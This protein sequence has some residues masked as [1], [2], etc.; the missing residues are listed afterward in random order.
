MYRVSQEEVSKCQNV[1]E[2]T[3]TQ[4]EKIVTDRQQS[5]D[6]L[7][8]LKLVQVQCT[9]INHMYIVLFMYFHF[10]LNKTLLLKSFYTLFEFTSRDWIEDHMS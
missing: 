5:I 7:D 1:E 4:L 6:A 10:F 9:E 8:E 2:S 3:I